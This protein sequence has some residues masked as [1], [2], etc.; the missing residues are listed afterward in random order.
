[1]TA[2]LFILFF[3]ALGLLSLVMTIRCWHRKKWLWGSINATLTLTLTLL[4]T[5]LLLLAGNLYNYHRLT[6][7]RLLAD[8]HIKSV[9]AQRYQLTLTLPQKKPEQ[10]D[11]R[12]DDWQID[13]RVLKWHSYANLLGLDLLYQ[14]ERLSGRFRDISQENSAQRSVYSLNV[15]YPI[16]IWQLA[17]RYPAW[18]PFVDAVYGSAAYVPLNNNAHYQVFATQSGLII[19]TGHD[20]ADKV[21]THWR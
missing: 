12:G 7:E 8:V 15:E 6:Y 20:V 10:F 4:S 1:M 21:I 13:A 16:D 18:L 5:T 11:I 2:S 14:F 17:R 9:G 3:L 19:R